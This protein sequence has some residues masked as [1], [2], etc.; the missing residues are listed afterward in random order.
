MHQ[1]AEAERAKMHAQQ[2]EFS[3]G[4][5]LARISN[6]LLN[7]DGHSYPLLLQRYEDRKV[8]TQ[9]LANTN[10][11]GRWVEWLQPSDATGSAP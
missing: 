6:D 7:N 9:H 2:Q 3:L 10:G 8:R 1:I 4:R 11:H 5:A